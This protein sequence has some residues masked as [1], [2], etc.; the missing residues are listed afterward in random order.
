MQLIYAQSIGLINP[1]ACIAQ[2]FIAQYH[3]VKWLPSLTQPRKV[4]SLYMRFLGIC[5]FRFLEIP[6][7]PTIP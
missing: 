1:K 7:K 5:T 6:K 3:S 2:E 4:H